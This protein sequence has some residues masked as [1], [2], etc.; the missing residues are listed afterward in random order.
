MGALK[1]ARASG[2][3]MSPN[4]EDDEDEDVIEVT[5]KP[6][7]IELIVFWICTQSGTEMTSVIN[8]HFR[9]E[10]CRPQ[11]SFCCLHK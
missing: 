9:C 11:H 1:G 7:Y 8:G 4:E 5:T 10:L 3:Q 6:H 2:L